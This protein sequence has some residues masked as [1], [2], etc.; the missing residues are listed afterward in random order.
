[1]CNQVF[2]ACTRVNIDSPVLTGALPRPPHRIWLNR[3]FNGRLAQWAATLLPESKYRF[4][5]LAN[6]LG[7]MEAGRAFQI[8]EVRI[9]NQDAKRFV[10]GMRSPPPHWASL[11]D[12][13]LKPFSL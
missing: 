13:G 7:K 5:Q 3:E 10:R 8:L 12:Y 6:V 2:D 4:P 9:R 11:V 1:M